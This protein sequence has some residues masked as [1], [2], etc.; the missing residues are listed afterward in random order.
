MGAVLVA[1][2]HSGVR[3]RSRVHVERDVVWNADFRDKA[4]ADEDAIND[5]IVS[6]IELIKQVEFSVDYILKRAE[7][8]RAAHGDG[9][10]RELR[11]E[12]SRAVDASSSL[13]NQRDLIED[14][15]E[16]VTVN[17]SIDDEWQAFIAVRREAELEA[18]IPDENLRADRTREFVDTAFRDRAIRTSGT[19]ITKVLPPASRFNADGGHGEKK[20]RVIEK[21][22]KYF[23]RFF[24]LSYGGK[25]E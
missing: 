4:K 8:Y 19:A 14:F 13:R 23:E 24:G 25:H 10:D 20:Q 6:E 15:V 12:I 11:A 5:G 16:R 22:G 9:D 21:L 7:K 17:G 18:I 2:V 3:R 1:V